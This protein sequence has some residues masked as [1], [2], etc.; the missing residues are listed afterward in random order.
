MPYLKNSTDARLS[1]PNYN[2]HSNHDP[3]N[4]VTHNQYTNAVR[5]ELGDWCRKNKLSPRAMSVQN[6]QDFIRHLN[7]LP[8]GHQISQFNKGV[9][10]AVEEARRLGPLLTRQVPKPG[11]PLRAFARKLPVVKLFFAGLVFQG[12]SSSARADGYGEKMCA[13]IGVFSVVSPVAYD[14]LDFLNSPSPAP[15]H[16]DQGIIGHTP[17]LPPSPGSQPPNNGGR[18]NQPTLQFSITN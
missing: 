12:A 3:L 10:A 18:A 4:G 11:G 17:R 13:V 7:S 2:W 6:G 16:Q 8:P 15:R 14:D 1:D 9:R 5:D